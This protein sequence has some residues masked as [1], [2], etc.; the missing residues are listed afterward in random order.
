MQIHL[1]QNQK[2]TKCQCIL[3]TD[4][5]KYA[6]IYMNLLTTRQDL[7]VVSNFST[8]SPQLRRIL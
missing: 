5:T 1:S 7:K 2:Q 4:N 6:N 8:Y 3:H